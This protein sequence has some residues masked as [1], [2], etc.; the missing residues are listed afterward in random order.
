MSLHK[1]KKKNNVQK[2]ANLWIVDINV[3][4]KINIQYIMKKMELILILN[5]KKIDIQIGKIYNLS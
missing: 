5:K 4:A 2:N 1:N 3:I